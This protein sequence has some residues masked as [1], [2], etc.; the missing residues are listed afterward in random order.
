[1]IEAQG[2]SAL[3][4]AA[5]IAAAQRVEHYEIAAYGAAGNFALRLALTDAAEL[6]QE[7]LNEEGAADHKLTESAETS[8]DPQAARA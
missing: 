1:V 7:S 8:I 2:D 6:L 3:R 4:H 5:L